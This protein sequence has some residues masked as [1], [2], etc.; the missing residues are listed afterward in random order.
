MRLP[1]LTQNGTYSVTVASNDG[2]VGRYTLGFYLNSDV[3]EEGLGGG[4]NDTPPAA[5][6]IDSAFTAPPV[7][8]SRGP[9]GGSSRRLLPPPAAPGAVRLYEGFESGALGRRGPPTVPHRPAALP[10]PPPRYRAQPAVSS[11]C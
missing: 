9:A 7:R 3:E 6:S 10:L 2:S 1:G 11:H 8:P 5:Q 4:T